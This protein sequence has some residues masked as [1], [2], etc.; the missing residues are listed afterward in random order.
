[1]VSC[2]G[3]LC[4]YSCAGHQQQ[5]DGHPSHERGRG[6]SRSRPQQQDGVDQVAT[7]QAHDQCPSRRDLLAVPR[8]SRPLDRQQ[9][10]PRRQHT[11][12]VGGWSRERPRDDRQDWWRWWRQSATDGVR[13][14]TDLRT[15]VPPAAQTAGRGDV[16]Q[17]QPAGAD[18]EQGRSARHE[19]G[20]TPTAVTPRPAAPHWPHDEWTRRDQHKP[21]THLLERVARQCA[22]VSGA[23]Y[24]RRQSQSVWVEFP[25]GHE[26]T[27]Q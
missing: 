1:M 4:V 13:R 21:T 23:A 24:R 3:L 10:G 16:P 14:G 22:G 7:Q 25:A 5:L 11:Q 6:G 2:K 9:R 20:D 27:P 19:H 12:P 18:Q 17:W 15:A 26:R 8:P